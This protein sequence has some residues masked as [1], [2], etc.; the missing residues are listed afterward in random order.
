MS[1][2]SSFPCLVQI[3][4]GF[5][6]LPGWD[7]MDVDYIR[8]VA[9]QCHALKRVITF[10]RIFHIARDKQRPSISIT[11]VEIKATGMP[12]FE[13]FGGTDLEGV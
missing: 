8:T 3:D 9:S 7:G 5:H 2:L 12:G 1:L 4:L 6:R 10:Y 13:Y 11:V